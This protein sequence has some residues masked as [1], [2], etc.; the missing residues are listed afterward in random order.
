MRPLMEDP[1]IGHVDQQMIDRGL[2]VQLNVLS[3]RCCRPQLT[4]IWK[5]AWQTGASRTRS[6]SRTTSSGSLL[7]GRRGAKMSWFRT[8]LYEGGHA[9]YLDVCLH[10]G[11]IQILAV[12]VVARGRCRSHSRSWLKCISSNVV[13]FYVCRLLRHV[14]ERWR[15]F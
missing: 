3:C 14:P 5:P 10:H 13:Q 6:L 1:S 7:R 15:W 8:Y 12:R 9:D 11:D 2:G 4:R